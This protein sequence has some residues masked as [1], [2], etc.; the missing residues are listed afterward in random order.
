M[1]KPYQPVSDE[2]TPRVPGISSAAW[3]DGDGDGRL[4]APL[5]HAK[6]LIAASAGDPRALLRSLAGYDRAVAMHAL[7]LLRSRGE[8]DA[9]VRSAF[10]GAPGAAGDGYAL[11]V[12]EAA[13]LKQ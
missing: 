8:F 11:F 12:E 3:V 1:R 4:T 2:W 13:R 9:R 6:R 10:A 5:A 7:E